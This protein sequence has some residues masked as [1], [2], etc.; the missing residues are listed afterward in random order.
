MILHIMNKRI[1]QQ[2]AVQ[3]IAAPQGLFLHVFLFFR[4]KITQNPDVISLTDVQSGSC[5]KPQN[6]SFL[7]AENH[8]ENPHRILVYTTICIYFP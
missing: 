3:K 6:F 4:L 5:T 1:P 2:Q 8:A 7:P